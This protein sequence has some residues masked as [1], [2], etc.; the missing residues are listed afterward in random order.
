VNKPVYV[1]EFVATAR[2]GSFTSMNESQYFSTQLAAIENSG[3]PLASVWVYDRK[4]L[5][6]RSN[7]TFDNDRAYMLRMI[8]EF[9][10]AVHARN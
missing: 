1:E 9:D 6:D 3:V 8:A 7:L 2:P 5:P 4:L 10:K